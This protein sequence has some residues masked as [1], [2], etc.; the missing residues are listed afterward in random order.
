MKY[1]ETILRHF[2]NPARVGEPEEWTLHGEATNPVCL[3]RMRLYLLVRDGR[4]ADAGFLAEGCVPTMAAGSWL[5]DWAVGRTTAEL[6]ALTPASIEEALGGLPATKRHAA[7]LAAETLAA[8]LAG[9][10]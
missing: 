5:A 4:V 6:A 7:H 1:S 10:R 3:D 8:A 9:A 2:Q